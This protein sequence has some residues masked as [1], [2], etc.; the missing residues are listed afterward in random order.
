MGGLEKLMQSID[1]VLAMWA[2]IGGVA[3]KFY[4]LVSVLKLKG[5]PAWWKQANIGYFLGW[6]VDPVLSAIFVAVLVASG[7]VFGPWVAFLAGFGGYASLNLIRRFVDFFSTGGTGTSAGEK[8]RTPSF[9]DGF[10]LPEN[11]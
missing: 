5:G 10:K 4:D 6:L 2:Y 9:A 8:S 1:L 11:I 3:L 7:F